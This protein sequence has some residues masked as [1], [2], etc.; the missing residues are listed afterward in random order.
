MLEIQSQV[1]LS[2]SPL[3]RDL[4]LWHHLVRLLVR[5]HLPVK[6]LV[7]GPAP[8]LL[9]SP[10]PPHPPNYISFK[11]FTS[12]LFFNLFHDFVFLENF[13][14]KLFSQIFCE[15]GLLVTQWHLKL[16]NLPHVSSSSG[17]SLILSPIW[18]QILTI[19]VKDIINHY[20]FSPKPY[21]HQHNVDHF[22]KIKDQFYFIFERWR[23][24]VYFLHKII[25][26]DSWAIRS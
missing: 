2:P 23:Q 10:T 22:S 24:A 6:N 7:Y 17:T 13:G 1:T 15:F 20:R 26:V 25:E 16:Q 4:R 12:L 9:L 8:P 11:L 19:P 18:L 3:P 5:C 14:A 21:P